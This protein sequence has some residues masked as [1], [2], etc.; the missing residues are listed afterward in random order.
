MPP[1]EVWVGNIPKPIDTPRP[2]EIGQLFNCEWSRHIVIFFDMTFLQ[3]QAWILRY[4][5]LVSQIL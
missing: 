2:F 3:Y 5:R 4:P 1:A